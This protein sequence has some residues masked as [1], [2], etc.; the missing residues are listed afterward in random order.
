MPRH[1]QS[2]LAKA[3]ESFRDVGVRQNAMPVLHGL[4][5]W[6]NLTPEQ[7]NFILHYV[8]AG[9]DTAAIKVLYTQLH[10]TPNPNYS[11]INQM[12]NKANAKDYTP[13]YPTYENKWFKTL[14]TWKTESSFSA[15]YNRAFAEVKTV[16]QGCYDLQAARLI[17]KTNDI[18]EKPDYKEPRNQVNHERNI[19]NLQESHMRRHHFQ[20]K[21][22][23]D[24]GG[25]VHITN[26]NIIGW[27]RPDGNR[28]SVIINQN[29]ESV[30]ED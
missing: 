13:V 11:G 1:T 29:G 27:E 30:A 23:G 18:I 17:M 7:K 14:K 6:D 21:E 19:I 2:L 20:D 8:W 24:T 3:S 22:G 9:T 12:G 4:P 5:E 16:V 10:Q 26:I 28:D 15:I 25:G